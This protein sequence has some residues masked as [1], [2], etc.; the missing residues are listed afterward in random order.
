[1]NGARDPNV[2]MLDVYLL[3]VSRRIIIKATQ[4][5]PTTR[6][7][8]YT[9]QPGNFYLQRWWYISATLWPWYNL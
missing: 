7:H 8:F 2:I 9:P 1:M 3:L 5:T 6:I 4:F